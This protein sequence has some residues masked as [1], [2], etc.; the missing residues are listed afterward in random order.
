MI[1]LLGE[2]TRFLKG[3]GPDGKPVAVK[4]E[5]LAET[6]TKGV[7]VTIR[8]YP[9]SSKLVA[10]EVTAG[11]QADAAP[12]S[13]PAADRAGKR[14]ELPAEVFRRWTHSQEEAFEPAPFRGVELTGRAP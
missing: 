1:F 9:A 10:V 14:A 4:P 13:P 11:G 3:A 2:G 7:P 6:F 12:G 8:F 5:Q